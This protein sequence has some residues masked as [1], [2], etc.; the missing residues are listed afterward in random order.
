MTKII[1]LVSDQTKAEQVIN[2]LTQAHLGDIDIHTIDQWDEDA[3]TTESPIMPAYNASSGVAGGA[4]FTKS[5]MP[6][7]DLN[8][9][10]EQFFKR[11]V[12]KGGVVI[13]VEPADDN[14]VPN[15]IRILEQQSDHVVKI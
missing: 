14:D 15:V 8:E 9:E 12:Q 4:A 5:K 6:S 7:L 3:T 11:G 1:G 10:E 13:S 2:K